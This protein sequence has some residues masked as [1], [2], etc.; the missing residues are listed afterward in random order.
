MLQRADREPC[1]EPLARPPRPGVP[2][3]SLQ[4]LTASCRSLPASARQRLSRVASLPRVPSLRSV[5]ES[6]GT[7]LSGERNRALNG[8]ASELE[9]AGGPSLSTQCPQLPQPLPGCAGQAPG[10]DVVDAAKLQADEAWMSS[11]SSRTQ[12]SS[13][14]CSTMHKAPSAPALQSQGPCHSGRGSKACNITPELLLQQLYEQPL[15]REQKAAV[16]TACPE[17]PWLADCACRCPLTPAW[18]EVW[19]QRDSIEI[20]EPAYIND[21]TGEVSDVPPQLQHF[22]SLAWFLVRARLQ[23]EHAERMAARIGAMMESAFKQVRSLSACWTGPHLDPSSGR[24]YFHC[25]S[26]G[27]SSWQNPCKELTFVARCAERL[28]QSSAFQKQPNAALQ[29]QDG[30]RWESISSRTPHSSTDDSTSTLAFS[31]VT[32]KQAHD[33]SNDQNEYFTGLESSRHNLV[34]RAVPADGHHHTFTTS[35]R[36]SYSATATSCRRQHHSITSEN[37]QKATRPALQLGPFKQRLPTPSRGGTK[38]GSCLQN[39]MQPCVQAFGETKAYQ[40]HRLR[41]AQ[42]QVQ[43]KAAW[44]IQPL[45]PPPMH[46]QQVQ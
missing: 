3:L 46:V 33:N 4:G 42:A 29:D 10:G 16:L 1:P 34:S 43:A 31:T 28:L 13:E 45:P 23:P 38:T 12:N 32:P 20:R 25:T 17:V 39:Q 40:L 11:R 14:G 27:V 9:T 37:Q 5:R 26:A 36:R 35:K 2:G 7:L 22:V 41:L 44:V 8:A 24:D 21:G 18:R 30:L 6:L 19:L 15:T